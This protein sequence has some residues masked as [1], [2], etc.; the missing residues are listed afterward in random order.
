MKRIL[1]GLGSLAFL[2]LLG[3]PLATAQTITTVVGTGVAGSTGDGAPAAAATLNLP[4]RVTTD[5]AG[6]LFIAERA[7]HRIRRVDAASGDITTVAGTGTAGFSGDGAAAT[8]AQLNS[9][10]DVAVDPA[11]GDLIIADTGNHRIRR[12]D[13]ATGDIT[14]VVGDGTPG[15]TGDTGPGVAAQLNSPFGVVVLANGDVLITDQNNNRIRCLLAVN[16]D[17]VAFAGTGVA[18]FSGDGAQGL[19]A[20]MSQPRGITRNAAGDVFFTDTDNHRIRRLSSGVITTVAGVGTAGFSGDGGTAITAQLNFPHG[21]AVHP[22]GSLLIADSTNNRVR[23]VGTN[24]NISTFAGTGTAGSAG[25]TGLAPSAQLSVPFGLA[26]DSNTNL[27]VADRD[28]NKIRRITPPPTGVAPVITTQPQSASLATGGSVSLNV[29]ASGA[30]SPTFQWFFTNGLIPGATLPTLTFNPAQVT[31]SGTYFVVVTNSVG[32]ATSTIVTLT[33]TNSTAPPAITTQPITQTVIRSNNV[34]F[35][36]SANGALPLAYQWFFNSNAVGGA[37]SPS[38]TFNNVQTNAAGDY[39]V[40]VTNSFGSLTSSIATLTVLTNSAPPP[41][42]WVVSGS[43]T[44]TDLSGGAAADA[45]GNTYLAASFQG[46]ATI[47][48]VSITTLGSFDALFAKF[49]SAGKVVWLRQDGSGSGVRSDRGLGITVDAAGNVY[50]CGW[51]EGA[52][53]LGVSQIFGQGGDEGFAVKF[54]TNGVRQ[55]I[56]GFGGG[57]DDKANAVA[58][59]ASGN[60]FVAGDL[61]GGPTFNSAVF[62]TITVTN[63]SVIN[64]A[65]NGFVAKYN[66][67]GTV[68]WAFSYGGVNNNTTT[69]GIGTDAAGNAYVVGSFT[70]TIQFGTNTVTYTAGGAF[71][72]GY[73]AKV[74]PAGAVVWIRT[75][76]RITPA[77]IAVRADGTCYLTGR[78]GGTQTLGPNTITAPPNGEVFLAKFDNTGGPV[79]ARQAA[80][81]GNSITAAGLSVDSQENIFISGHFNVGTSFGGNALTNAGLLDTFVTKYDAAGNVQWAKRA[82]GTTDEFASGIAADG[83]GNAFL[84][85]SYFTNTTFDAL[86]LPPSQFGDREFFISKIAAVGGPV[87]VPSGLVG[88]WAGDGFAVDYAWTNHALTT[89]LTFGSGEVQ[90]ALNY[91]GSNS[92]FRVPESPALNVGAGPGFT[93]ELWLQPR[94]VQAM[95]PLVE[96][97]DLSGFV[98]PGFPAPQAGIRSH[99]WINTTVGLPSS[100]GSIY[101][102]LI[103]TNGVNNSFSTPLNLLR[104]LQ[105]QH[106]AMTYSQTNGALNIYLDGTLVG[107]TNLPGNPVI[108]T[109]DDMLAGYRPSGVNVGSVLNGLIDE[110]SIYNRALAPTEIQAIVAA[111]TAGKARPAAPTILVQPQALTVDQGAP[112][113]LGVAAAGYA[114]LAYQWR[115]NGTNV[116]GQTNFALTVPAAYSVHEGSYDVRITQLDSVAV[117][118]AAATLNVLGQGEAKTLFATN[119][120]VGNFIRVG[121]GAVLWTLTG[122]NTLLVVPS[123]GSI[124]STQNFGDFILHA[125]FR[126]PSPTDAGNGNSGIYLQNR[127][128]IQIFNSF[129]VAVPGGN[130]IGAVWNQTP[131]SVNAALPAGQ[132]QTYDITFHQAQWNGNTKVA[133]ARVTVV[134]N[135]VTVQ[136][137]TIVTGPTTGGVAE[138]PTPGPVVLQDNGSSVQFRNIRITPLDLPPEFQRAL[139]AGG[140]QDDSLLF[141]SRD[142]ADNTYLSGSFQGTTTI[143]TNVL[144]SSGLYDAYIAKVSA[145]GTVLWARKVGGTGDESGFGVAAVANGDVFFCGRFQN[146]ANFGTTNLTASGV[147]DLFLARYDSNGNLIW[148]RKA[149]GAGD[150]S[151]YAVAAD[152]AGNAYVS[153][154]FNGTTDLGGI[155]FVSGSA[156]GNGFVAKYGPTGALVWASALSGTGT[157]TARKIRLDG[158]TNV[159]VAGSFQGTIQFVTPFLSSAG[160]DDAYVLKLSSAGVTQWVQQFGAGASDAIGALDLGPDGSVH[161]AGN[162]RGSVAFGTNTLNNIGGADVFTAKLDP[163]GNVLWARQAGGGGTDGASSVSVDPQGK[164]FV[165]GTY[166]NAA[167]FS[168]TPLASSGAS[169]LFVVHYDANGIQRWVRSSSNGQNI[170]GTEIATDSTVGLLV[171][172]EFLGNLAL[173]A[174]PLSSLG[175]RDVFHARITSTPP[176]ISQQP[177]GGNVLAGKNS[178]FTIG[179]TG[180]GGVTYQWRLNGTNLAGATNAAYTIVNASTNAAGT[181]D[182]LVTHA[183]GSIASTPA[184][185][186][187]TP[188][189]NPLPFTAAVR[190]GGTGAD[191]VQALARD[192]AGNSYLAGFFTGT[193]ALG[194]T[195]LVSAGGDDIFVAKVSPAGTVLWAAHCGGPGE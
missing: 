87:P 92:V 130:D 183:F 18:G 190:L 49:D 103:S 23:L 21:I 172:G 189:S 167:T 91:N 169:D 20:R 37:T 73:I 17:I 174:I 110:L 120:D 82:G 57:G 32:S 141:Q 15:N 125:E 33:I 24:G 173:D 134:L 95:Q 27:F 67:S 186:T 34:T 2:L 122:S 133:N 98:P 72:D 187:V 192:A 114:P 44:N 175:Q 77:G 6:N 162:F 107:S 45:A 99:F 96:W 38:L 148:A 4:Y 86:S 106:V 191:S 108:Y 179:A 14:T 80:T 29:T 184:V 74:S 85:G 71:T 39:F 112:A 165:A 124:Q 123:T 168:A 88:W 188:S 132:W 53:Q 51:F 176:V 26:F 155:Q 13:V 101:V 56:K 159:Y 46:T 157:P 163:A 151:A 128:E 136:N 25:D 11:N 150:D 43:S 115:L 185:V 97:H 81:T 143:G 75:Y 28:N 19:L 48:G 145:S 66:P 160:S 55:W 194:T 149:G 61:M 135:G 154:E 129:G 78:F 76:P 9:P 181:Y 30:P 140:T 153:G 113:T 171:S 139:S 109:R 161:V 158:A 41:F 116:P 100:P 89:N 137:E 93:I 142:A 104:L 117:T 22:D 121:G 111:G 79:W 60:L 59:D 119:S 94:D 164:V 65:F 3:A 131:A 52:Y 70:G 83:A 69:T 5:A 8:A 50:G 36:V 16:S 118:S 10:N 126:C 138:G 147:G 193:L 1:S 156:S 127:Y 144:V 42:Q 166:N 31:N 58:T 64:S 68:Q 102:N 195:N 7:G 63:R 146:T 40:I 170:T 62:D 47:G 105:W 152:A 35:S 84:V 178:T 182:V 12:V 90:Q 180:T 54:D 177:I